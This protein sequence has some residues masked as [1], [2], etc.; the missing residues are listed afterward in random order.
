M[1]QQPGNKDG[2]IKV[3]SEHG[4]GMAYSWNSAEWVPPIAI[5]ELMV[6]VIKMLKWFT[7]TNL[8]V[9]SNLRQICK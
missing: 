8:K 7:G 1:L 3:V 4:G 9:V 5:P 2:Q 6:V